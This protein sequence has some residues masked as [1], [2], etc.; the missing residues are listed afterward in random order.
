MLKIT[1]KIDTYTPTKKIILTK[2]FGMIKNEENLSFRKIKSI[3]K[4]LDKEQIY[5]VFKNNTFIGFLFYEKLSKQLIEL[6]GLYLRKEYRG[7]GYADKIMKHATKNKNFSYLGATFIKK[8][9]KM[10][11]NHHFNKIK[12]SD[13]TWQEKINFIKPRLKLYRL[14]EV[15]RHSKK[16]N[17]IL[18]KKQ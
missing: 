1:T 11:L 7:K 9:Q 17:L 13:L 3:E 4:Y 8:I 12:F 18:M 16:A 14:K 2:I 10:L 5:L 6:H 15:F